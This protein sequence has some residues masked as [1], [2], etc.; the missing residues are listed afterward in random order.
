MGALASLQSRRHPQ[1]QMGMS[2]ECEPAR[3]VSPA[4]SASESATA[5]T[6]VVAACG[7]NMT[8]I[9]SPSAKDAA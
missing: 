3:R 2:V 7:M 8:V 1:I 9:I 5:E 4:E 6:H